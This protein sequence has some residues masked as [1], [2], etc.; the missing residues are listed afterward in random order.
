[1]KKILIPI[2]VLI[3]LNS[4]AQNKK[5][6]KLD[7]TNGF[8]GITLGDTISQFK[9][10]IEPQ[11]GSINQVKNRFV[12]YTV[13]D[14]SLLNLMSGIK[15]TK[16]EIQF[17]ERKLSSINIWFDKVYLAA[18]LDRFNK[19]YGIPSTHDKIQDVESIRWNGKVNSILIMF[20]SADNLILASFTNNALLASHYNNKK[21]DL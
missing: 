10:N 18:L 15:L 7:D 2:L 16:I 12:A 9:F 1:M 19:D 5:K 11:P 21:K 20:D 17:Y 6:S 13:L 3:S 4:F 14:D 8:A